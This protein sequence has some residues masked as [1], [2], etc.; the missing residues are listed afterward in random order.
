MT[1]MEM[2]RCMMKAKELPNSFWIEAVNAAVYILNRSY[3]KAVIGMTPHE[4]YSGKKPSVAHFRVFGSECYA[5]IP[6]SDRKKLDSKNR[7]C[8]FLGYSDESKAY[9]I[10]D[11]E[12]KKTLINRDVVFV[13]EP[14]SV[15]GD[16]QATLS[17]NEKIAYQ[18][19]YPM[20]NS[21][22]K[23]ENL[24]ENEEEKI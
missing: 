10:Y 4:A 17:S 19:P 11:K 14:H 20:T 16:G 21:P 18:V 9:K 2:A 24:S 22:L 7:V 3:T 6:D 5:H 15:A 1:V 13:E 12:A 8:I 23:E